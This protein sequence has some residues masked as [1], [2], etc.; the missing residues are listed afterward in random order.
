MHVRA[1]TSKFRNERLETS[2]WA[3]APVDSESEEENGSESGKN[4][5]SGSEEESSDGETSTKP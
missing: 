3:A 1:E 5:E 4:A 2:D